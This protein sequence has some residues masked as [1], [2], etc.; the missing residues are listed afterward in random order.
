MKIREA[1]DIPML[2]V[3]DFEIQA[4]PRTD[5]TQ[6]VEFPLLHSIEVQR[7]LALLCISKV[8][9]CICIGH[10]LTV[11][12][13]F[14]SREN[15]SPNDTNNSTMLL[16]PNKDSNIQTVEAVDTELVAWEASLPECCEYR[17]LNAR[18]ATEGKSSIA[19]H[20]TLLHM[21]HC[22]TISAL[23]RPRLLPVFLRGPSTPRSRVWNAVARITEMVM[24]LNDLKLEGYLPPGAIMAILPTMIVHMIEMKNPE[25]QSRER[26]TQGFR[27]CMLLI[28][29]LRATYE[30]ADFATEVLDAGMKKTGLD[31]KMDKDQPR[32]SGIR[33]RGGI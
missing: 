9:L 30:V 6:P 33:P 32:A 5:T 10:T 24:G 7:E 28:E 25:L 17:P 13:A 27:E 20:R 23:H 1:F 11:Q 14:L 15:V 8:K 16:S 18:D 26:A 21:I 3:S 19:L 29:Q 31:I 22:A 12:Y 4:L 2:E